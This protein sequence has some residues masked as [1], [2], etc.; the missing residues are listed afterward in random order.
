MKNRIIAVDFGTDN[1]YLAQSVNGGPAEE[2][3][4]AVGGDSAHGMKSVIMYRTAG[5]NAG[6]NEFGQ[7]AINAFGGASS[8]KKDENGYQLASR[9]ML[10][11]EISEKAREDSIC[12]LTNLLTEANK[13]N[14][15]I[16]P[17]EIDIIFSVPNGASDSYCACLRNIARKAGWGEVRLLDEAF[18]SLCYYQDEYSNNVVKNIFHDATFIINFDDGVCEFVVIKDGCIKYSWSDMLLGGR[19]FDDLFYQWV[20]DCTQDS[21]NPVTEEQLVKTGKDF[22]WR[23]NM[24]QK[25]KDRFL[26]AMVKDKEIPYEE[27]FVDQYELELSWDEFVRRA[28]NYHPSQSFMNMTKFPDNISKTILYPDGTTDLLYGFKREFY[29]ALDISRIPASSIS[30]VLLTGSCSYLPFVR[31]ICKDVFGEDKL[32]RATNPFAAISMGLIKYCKIKEMAM[33]KIQLL[34]KGVQTQR[35]I[36]AKNALDSLLT[37]KTIEL[38]TQ[39]AAEIFE[40]FAMPKLNAFAETGGMLNEMEMSIIEDV[41]NNITAVLEILTPVFNNIDNDFKIRVANSEKKMIPMNDTSRV[42]LNLDNIAACLSEYRC[43]AI[44]SGMGMMIV[45]TMVD[46]F[47]QVFIP[48]W[49][50]LA[51]LEGNASTV[52]NAALSEAENSVRSTRWTPQQAAWLGSSNILSRIQKKFS[53][54]FPGKFNRFFSN[55]NQKN[56]TNIE[57]VIDR[58]INQECERYKKFV[59]MERGARAGGAN[60]ASNFEEVYGIKAAAGGAVVMAGPVSGGDADPTEEKTYFDVVLESIGTKKLE[61]I[62]V[63]RDTT[64]LGLAEAKELVESAPSKIK[65][66]I[67]RDDA[68]KLKKE[69]EEAGASVSLK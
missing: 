51:F 21:A 52:S 55:F 38:L 56:R 54:E 11:I 5:D 4:I 18:A 20:I 57:N 58:A 1:T 63:V 26:S 24:S 10:N 23:C 29:R 14:L 64:G 39:K 66:A 22:Y 17:S 25:L 16:V 53:E 7:E 3:N 9:F 60:T 30:K 42:E 32:I 65:E 2:F 62:R 47:N 49:V 31:D 68:E 40:K 44:S 12:F 27:Y 43:G 69:F 6:N 45:R 37:K 35:K 15:H 34:Q 13:Q 41:N 61:V 59:N 48:V 36:I 46:A 19:L 8:K 33:N 28:Q 67:S 50:S